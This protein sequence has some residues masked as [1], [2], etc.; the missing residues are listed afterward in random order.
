M[1]LNKYLLLSFL[2][3]ISAGG[4]RAQVLDFKIMKK[5]A[6][7]SIGPAAMSGRITSV[8]VDLKNNIYYAGAASGGVWK[9][10]NSGA[11]WQ[12]IFEEQSTQSI[13]AVSV[14]QSNP[15][16]IW[17]GT[18]EGNPRNSQN[19]GDG[20][21][22]SINGGKN[23][24]K[25]GLSESR[26]IHRIII[27][28]N[29]PSIV[30]AAVLGSTN[31]PSAMRGVY[32]TTDGGKTWKR[33]LF[34]NELT[35]CAD[36]VI[37][38]SNPNKLIAAMWEYRRYPWEFVSGGAGSGIYTTYDGGE[39]WE[40]K[41][42]TDGLP[43][44]NLGRCGLAIC[45]TKPN[46]VY[47]IVE[48]K[49]NAI[50]RSDDGGTTFAKVGENGDRPFYYAEIYCD[51]LNEN[52]LYNI[53]S[54]VAKSEDGGKTWKE[55]LGYTEGGVHPDH[56][57]FY[58][59]P[60]NPNLI[61][62]GNDGGMNISRDGGKTFSFV[63]N[64]PVGQ[65]YHVNIDD[66]IPYNL[67]GGLQ[68]N[69]TWVGPSQVW[70]SGGIRNADWQE[71][72]FGDGFDC[73]PR[74]DNPRYAF[75]MSQGG[76]LAYCDKQ[77]GVTQNIQPQHP[78]GVTLR[79]NWNAAMA[80]DPYK[81]C[82]IYYGS[83][84]VH[85]SSDCGQTWTI[86]SPDLTTSDTFKI[87]GAKRSGGLT[88]D[89]TNAENHCTILAIAPS[90]TDKNVIWAS[91]DD[92]N[93]QITT[94]GGKKWTNLIG[95]ISGAPKNA[96]IPQI[97]VTKNAGEAFVIVNNYR[98]NDWKPYAYHTTDYGKTWQRIVNEAQMNT[99]TLSF[100]CDT[101]V[102]NLWFLGTDNGL[103]ISMDYGKNWN[104]WMNG[105]PSVPTMDM[106][107]H[108][109]TNDLVIATFGRAFYILDDIQFLRDIAKTNGQNL[110]TELSVS[111]PAD[112]YLAYD[113]S[114]SGERF[115][116]SAIYEGKNKSADAL[117][118]VWSTTK[119][120]DST[121]TKKD[122]AKMDKKEDDAKKTLLYVIS[123]SND[124][125][126]KIKITLDSGM[127]RISWDL[128]KRGPKYPSWREAKKDDDS[129]NGSG[130]RVSA[131]VYKLVVVNGKLKDSTEIT[132]KDDPRVTV[133]DADKKTREAALT[134]ISVLTEEST[135]AF[136][137]LKDADKTVGVLESQTDLSS[138][139]DS[140]K[141]NVVKWGKEMK[142][143]ILNLQKMFI[144]PRDV[145]GIVRTSDG[146]MEK[147]GQAH[148]MIA[149]APG[150][151]TTNTQYAI[152]DAKKTATHVFD[153]V[154][155]FFKIDWAKYR[156]KMDALKYPVFK[157]FTPLRVGE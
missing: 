122:G 102:P 1:K 5:I 137:L 154:N 21:Y 83:Q 9:S 79:Y 65:F 104:K 74:R 53:F 129:D 59:H 62:N 68:D 2:I 64:I 91:T 140:T 39:N 19:F 101:Q 77:S 11:S 55:I 123:K 148:Q 6:P 70:R 115:N 133:T 127:N 16:E 22:K 29:N 113:R 30:Y 119:K 8:D 90:P 147:I 20:I 49:E 155:D 118:T 34:N 57:A 12:P 108:P 124:T 150:G 151:L 107:I 131:G 126:R 13:G 27:D 40:K 31:G 63:T 153:K 46:V 76:S 67:Y 88:P 23:W 4:M 72:Y 26:S 38:P 61:I 99:Y 144:A 152:T 139:P 45:K 96:W 145:K 92:G 66:A 125:L 95:N 143:S 69:G 28:P 86:I 100:T 134:N 52:R 128:R 81:D 146:L 60:E 14:N 73:M 33:L 117:I 157:E 130:G 54:R 103:F 43:K 37:D 138:A 80:Q 71:L 94:D 142:D 112:A 85:Y 25:M 15:S 51:P 120:V 47:A 42:D 82:G 75:A 97:E 78:D 111:K 7:R 32:K 89:V 58:I 116:A 109:A 135:K 87:N 56:H 84:F 149:T 132:V 36:L 35:G 106:K 24:E 98:Q 41:K 48:A 110:K 3:F 136:D 93:I 10:V 156:Q 121:T 18:G 141:K 17:V 50:Y 114:F 105:Y 44:G